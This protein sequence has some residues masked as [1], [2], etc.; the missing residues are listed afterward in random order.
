MESL[1]LSQPLCSSHGWKALIPLPTSSLLPSSTFLI[2]PNRKLGLSTGFITTETVPLFSSHIFPCRHCAVTPIQ[3]MHFSTKST[4]ASVQSATDG[5]VE[6]KSKDLSVS[7]DS[8]R[9]RF[10][11]FYATRVHKVLPSA[12]LVPD[13]PTVLLTIVGM[14]QFKPI[15]LGQV[16]RQVP[17][18][19]TAQRCIRTNDVE[20]V[21]R[22]TRHHTFFEMLG[23]F[24]FGDY[25]KSEA[26]Q[27][28]WELSTVEFGLPVNRLWISVFEEDNEAFEIWHDEMGIPVERIK[29]MG[30][31]DNFGLVELLVHVVHALRFITISILRGDML[32][33]F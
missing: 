10:L 9:C 4:P 16:P 7:G 22:T 29:R 11:D 21:G 5:L 28:A 12:S 17:R 23:N 2:Y 19:T 14:L 27:W 8:I 32:I 13:D 15:F 6:G 18:A 33:L 3:S 20:N 31:E 30:E 25:F 24:T 26:I 1:K